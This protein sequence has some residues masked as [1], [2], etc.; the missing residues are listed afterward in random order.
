MTLKPTCVAGQ[1]TA[2]MIMTGGASGVAHPQ[3]AQDPQ[4]ITLKECT[5]GTVENVVYSC[6]DKG[7]PTQKQQSV[8]ENTERHEGLWLFT[9]ASSSS[10]VF[11][12]MEGGAMNICLHVLNETKWILSF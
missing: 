3:L 8:R 6:F 9:V 10:R 11:S 5:V 7:G 2:M 12:A 1:M 4:L